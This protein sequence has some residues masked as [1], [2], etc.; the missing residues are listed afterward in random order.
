MCRYEICGVLMA[1][2]NQKI[3]LLVGGW[4]DW[5]LERGCRGITCIGM[6]KIKL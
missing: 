3:A 2:G 1:G 6:K 4:G 5:C